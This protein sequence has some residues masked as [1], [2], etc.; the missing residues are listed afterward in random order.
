MKKEKMP[1]YP[2]WEESELQI[3]RFCA[4]GTRIAA[5]EEVFCEKKKQILAED[6]FCK[7]YKYDI[8]KKELRRRKPVTKKFEKGDF[9]I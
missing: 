1:V 9:E 4:F 7:K 6:N 5:S 2:I 3:C 8:L